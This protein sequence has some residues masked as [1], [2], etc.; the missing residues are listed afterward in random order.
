M[1]ITNTCQHCHATQN[2][3][4]TRKYQNA[5]FQLFR[6]LRFYCVTFIFY[7]QVIKLI[8]ATKQNECTCVGRHHTLSLVELVM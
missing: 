6:T 8:R 7:G 1:T 3:S 5:K 2:I 4:P